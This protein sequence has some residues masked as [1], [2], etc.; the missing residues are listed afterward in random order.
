MF[1]KA[2]WL[3]EREHSLGFG[4]VKWGKVNSFKGIRFT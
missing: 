2:A 1:Y 3:V 4:C